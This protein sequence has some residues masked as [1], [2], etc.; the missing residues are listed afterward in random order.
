MTRIMP[1]PLIHPGRLGFDIDG[2]VADTMEAFIRIAR[3]EHGVT[4]RSEEITAFQVEDCL[5]MDPEVVG[6][7]F[8]YLMEDPLGAGL[9]LMPY[10]GMVLREFAGHAPLTFI[11]A[12]PLAAP[13][14]DWLRVMLGDE[15]YRETRLVAT[16]EHDDKAR[17]IRS[18]GLSHFIDDRAQTCLMLEEAGLNP[19]VFSQPWNRGR[20]RLPEVTNWLA[21]RS[22]CLPAGKGETP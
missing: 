3:D 2:V 20:H 9:R 17:H 16:G 15:V 13:I 10:A 7:I 18:M 14:A 4:V 5:D 19:I 1:S 22:L 8:H 21:I 11:T 6:E 12:R